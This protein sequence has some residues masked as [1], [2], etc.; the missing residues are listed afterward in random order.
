VVFFSQAFKD[1]SK[2]GA[3]THITDD[4]ITRS[5]LASDTSRARASRVLGNLPA[6]AA[7][8]ASATHPP[9]A[10]VGGCDGRRRIRSKRVPAP[11]LAAGGRLTL[12]RINTRGR[13]ERRQSPGWG[14]PYLRVSCVHTPT[15]TQFHT[16]T[17]ARGDGR[18]HGHGVGVTAVELTP[19]A[20][21]RL[22]LSP[23][24]S[25]LVSDRRRISHSARRI[26]H[27]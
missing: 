20:A 9:S 21:S 2:P 15:L 5:L 10:L 3:L 14:R 24:V 26:G 1:L 6:R 25:P 4:G 12:N 13:A 17:G 7:P 8:P 16:H 18:T 23:S 11:P 19:H 27:V 22:A